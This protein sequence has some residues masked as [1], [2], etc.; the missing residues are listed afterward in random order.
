MHVPHPDVDDSISMTAVLADDPSGVQYFFT[1]TVNGDVSGW[2]DSPVWTNGNLAPGILYAYRVKSRDKSARNGL[3]TTITTTS[4][5]SNMAVTSEIHCCARVRF[6]AA[7]ESKTP[8]MLLMGMAAS[9]N[10]AR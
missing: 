9:A 1:N 3:S 4:L 7:A 6:R 5:R 10:C 8:G 2:Q